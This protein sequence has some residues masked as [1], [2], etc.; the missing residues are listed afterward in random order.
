MAC[1]SCCVGEFALLPLADFCGTSS[2][3]KIGISTFRIGV[4][5]PEGA[6]TLDLLSPG[7]NLG[8]PLKNFA[9]G[10]IGLR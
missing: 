8:C 6:P 4:P 5:P 3:L 2:T 7:V 10:V 9:R 1:H